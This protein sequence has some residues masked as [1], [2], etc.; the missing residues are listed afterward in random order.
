[1]MKSCR[2][3]PKNVQAVQP[4]HLNKYLGTWYEMARFDFRF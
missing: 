4:F 1:L 3:I 2:T